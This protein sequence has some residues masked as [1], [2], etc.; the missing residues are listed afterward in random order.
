M[1]DPPSH[2]PNPSQ[3]SVPTILAS[4]DASQVSAPY[5]PPAAQAPPE[6]VVLPLA[7]DSSTLVHH[8]EFARR[9]NCDTGFLA[10]GK[11][12]AASEDTSSD[13]DNKE[14]ISNLTREFQETVAQIESSNRVAAEERMPTPEPEPPSPLY[15][16]LQ[17][18][19]LVGYAYPIGGVVP[20]VDDFPIPPGT[21]Y[22]FDYISE[23]Y[24][25][26]PLN[27]NSD[28]EMDKVANSKSLLQK[29][30]EYQSERATLPLFDRS[31]YLD[32]SFYVVG[33]ET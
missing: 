1:D 25:E 30:R 33:N 18:T 19:P 27:F 16:H 22:D 4:Q 29:L 10:T 17:T 21:S 26:L 3:D 14:G 13:D 24:G 20:D 15:D 12:D 8:S 7:A 2:P 31:Q 6:D 5:H 32:K 11:D 28:A 23:R 9:V